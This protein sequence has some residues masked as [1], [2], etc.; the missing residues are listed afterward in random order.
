MDRSVEQFLSQDALE[1]APQLLG[2]TFS[3]TID[4]LV[5]SVLLIEVEAYMGSDDPASHA[6]RGRTPRTEPMFHGGG[7]IYVYFVYGNHH[8]VNIVTGPEGSAQAVLLRGGIPIEGRATMERRRGRSENLANG[9]GRLGQA[10]GL[11]TRHSGMPIDGGMVSLRPG[12]PS[13][14]VKATPRIG[15]SKAVDRPW[16]FV[17]EA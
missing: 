9:P 14:T 1:V 17:L 10:L 8:C 2:W 11:T 7:V 5:T 3:T 12:T 16:R 4:D 6:H 13:G 15:I